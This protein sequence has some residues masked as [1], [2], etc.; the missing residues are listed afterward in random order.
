[1]RYWSL[2]LQEFHHVLTLMYTF[3]QS[4]LGAIQIY[5]KYIIRDWQKISLHDFL[6]TRVVTGIIF[7]KTIKLTGSID[8]VIVIL[9]VFL[10]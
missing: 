7:D 6:N 1:M 10:S 8:C 9:R 4:I 3:P 5:G 2:F